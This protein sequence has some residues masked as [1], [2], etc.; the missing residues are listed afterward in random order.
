M[1]VKS[2]T[3]KR[4]FIMGG[5]VLL[6]VLALALGKFLQIRKMIA[7]SP[8]P[9]AQTVTA[10]KVTALEWQPQLNAVGTLMPV[11]G[12]DVTTEIA[13]LV[14]SVNFRSGQDVAAGT[15][16]LQLNAEADIAQMRTLQAAAELAGTVL[17]RDREQ[18]AVEAISK[19]QLDADEADV[20]SKRA[21]VEQQAAN[22]AK[23]TIRAPFSG[24][25]GITAVH[26][27]Q[28]LNPGDKIVPLQTLD[29]IYANFSLPQKQ[30]AGL[31]VGQ[32]ATLTTDAYGT[33]PFVG[34]ITAIN[35]RIEADTRTMQIQ[36]TLPNPK[37]RL[38]PGM[39]ANVVIDVGAKQR[40][41][42]LPQTAITY[43]PYGSTVFVLKP[44]DSKEATA[45]KDARASKD[46][47]DAKAAPPLPA[48]T[49]VALQVFVT[50]GP[51]RGDQVAV[52]TGIKEGDQV[53]TSGQ[54][55]LKNGMP[56][57]VDNSIQPA[58]NPAPTPQ[59]K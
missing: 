30:V 57:T 4:M 22:V 33:E 21:S 19:A 27:G 32:V 7:S 34:R 35:P 13:G 11:R 3:K 42:T 39:F 6:L 25:L 15:V 26:E 50:T 1:A 8:K 55:K 23:R 45:A 58:N 36:A 10:V 18:Y 49:L 51:T 31:S 40:Y 53:V 14:R 54:L 29:P 52:L 46:G 59:E 38:L 37:R 20:K 41:L 17:A 28:Y 2:S 12:I 44:A 5:L 43:N 47:K 24:K 9:G 48:G 16:L 56:A